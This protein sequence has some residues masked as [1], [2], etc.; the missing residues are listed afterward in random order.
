[1]NRDFEPFVGLS[2]VLNNDSE[3]F[4]NYVMADLSYEFDIG[5]RLTI[6]PRIYYDQYDTDSLIEIFPDGYTVPFDLDGNGNIERFPDGVFSQAITT[7]RKSRSGD[8]DG[9]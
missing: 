1:M 5:E 3:Q 8:T 2:F 4:L 6:Q 9:L 7:S